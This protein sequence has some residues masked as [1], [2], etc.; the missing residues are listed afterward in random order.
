[1][2]AIVTKYLP[3]TNVRG[4]RVKASCQ[5]KSIIRSW[6]NSLNADQNHMA[7]AKELATMLG[8]NYGDW[9]GGWPPDG[10]GSVWVC[11]DARNDERFTVET[12]KTT[13]GARLSA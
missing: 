5:A 2:Q 9:V 3:A 4:S 6:D 10:K 11:T 13:M 12:T 7:A 8:W 1:M